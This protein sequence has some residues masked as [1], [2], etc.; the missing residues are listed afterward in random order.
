MVQSTNSSWEFVGY[1]YSG[2]PSNTV[3]IYEGDRNS[4]TNLD[5]AANTQLGSAEIGMRGGPSGA[6]FSGM[7]ADVQVYNTSLTPAQV[8]QI[9]LE[10]IGGA[11]IDLQNLVGWWPLNGNANDYS[12]NGNNGVPSG[13]TYTSNWESGYSAP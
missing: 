12:G 5:Y 8:N 4:T 7:I 6:Q 2:G 10:G 11:P 1:S 9:Y 3:E 13:V